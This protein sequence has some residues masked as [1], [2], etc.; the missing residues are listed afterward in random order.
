MIASD[1][2]E[3]GGMVT[4][5]LHRK[6]QLRCYSKR[7][8]LAFSKASCVSAHAAF[9]AVLETRLSS[10][11]SRRLW[12]ANASRVSARLPIGGD[13]SLPRLSTDHAFSKIV[14]LEVWKKGSEKGSVSGR[15]EVAQ[16]VS[17]SV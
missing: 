2:E 10:V 5:F 1:V 15:R 14:T 8:T 11:D 17:Q 3:S 7:A 4:P 16:T 9:A 13:V 12:R 6:P